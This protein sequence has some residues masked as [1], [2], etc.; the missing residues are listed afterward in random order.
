MEN[1]DEGKLRKSQIVEKNS[2]P[3]KED[4]EAEKLPNKEK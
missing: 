2:L 1:F 4:I 3:T